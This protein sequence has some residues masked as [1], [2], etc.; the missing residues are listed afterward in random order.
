MND[1]PHERRDI[2]ASRLSAG[3]AV[4]AAPLAVEFNVSEDAIRRDLRALAAQGLC[5][6]VYGGALPLAL[7]TSPASAPLAARLDQNGAAKDALAR[8]AATLVQAHELV[9]LDS[10]STNLAIV[11]HLPPG[12][13]LTIATNAIAIAA[14]VLKRPDLQ[15]IMIGGSVDAD[16]G[17]CIDAQAVASVATLN[18]DRCFLGACAVSAAAGIGAFGL[19]DATF[20]RA[21][22]A[23]SRHT[24][25]LATDDKLETRAPYRVAAAAEIGQLI[26]ESDAP[27]AQ[28]AA[29]ARAGLAVLKAAALS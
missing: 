8:T 7:P 5:R 4:V 10:G 17:G 13:G 15:L 20:K 29:F 6:R 23:A 22:L 18:I 16:V 24:A 12:Q 1:I 28:L 27:D 11:R 26:V 2:I 14:E 3:Q 9:F 25:I 21:L 19:A